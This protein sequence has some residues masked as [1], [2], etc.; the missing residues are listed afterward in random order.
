MSEIQPGAGFYDRDGYL[1]KLIEITA[2]KFYDG[3]VWLCRNMD[4]GEEFEAFIRNRSELKIVPKETMDDLDTAD[5]EELEE[6]A[7]IWDRIRDE[8]NNPE[9]R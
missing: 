1:C 2:R 6:A 4:T 7:E 5:N 9:E 8:S 3:A